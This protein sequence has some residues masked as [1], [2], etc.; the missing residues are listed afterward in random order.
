[1]SPLVVCTFLGYL[2]ALLLDHDI[3]GKRLFRTMVI[4]PFFLMTTASGVIW[5]YTIF[6]I[7]FG[8]YGEIV[9]TFGGVPSDPLTRYPMASLILIFIWQWMP[10]FI[11]IYLGAF[12]EFLRRLWKARKLTDAIGGC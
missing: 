9:R 2:I 11:M 3:P 5:K 6:N 7:S 12:K 1:M 10:F 8:W 4:T